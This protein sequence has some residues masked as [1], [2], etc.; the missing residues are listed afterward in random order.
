MSYK[1]LIFS[2]VTLFMSKEWE[3]HLKES[4]IISIIF[5]PGHKKS[6]GLYC[7]VDCTVTFKIQICYT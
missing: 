6:L 7:I 5:I 3:V 4:I 2:A 1:T